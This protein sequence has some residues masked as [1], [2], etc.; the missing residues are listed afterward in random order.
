MPSTK[1]DGPGRQLKLPAAPKFDA[2]GLHAHECECAR[3]ALGF[4]PTIAQ[5]DA[6]RRALARRQ[7]EK[8]SAAAASALDVRKEKKAED[9]R[10]WFASRAA[11]TDRELEK[12]RGPVVVPPADE[13]RALR[14]AFGLQTKR[15]K[16]R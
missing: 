13:L 16:E 9:R 14:E 1:G 11:E 7:A 15:P 12:F 10:A 4:R 6:A 8:A 5:R 3:C 2:T